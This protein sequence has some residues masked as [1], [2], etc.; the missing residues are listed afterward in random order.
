MLQAPVL[1]DGAVQR[2][3]LGAVA[4]DDFGVALAELVAVG[5]AVVGPVA[6]ERVAEEPAAD[7]A[8]EL[9]LAAVAGESAAAEFVAAAAESVAAASS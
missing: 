4:A 3:L 6:V 2:P 5:P 7:T 8:F 9:Q 1:A